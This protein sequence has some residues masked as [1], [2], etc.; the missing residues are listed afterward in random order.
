MADIAANLRAVQERVRDAALRSSRDPDEVELLVV[1]KTWPVPIVEEVIA[2]G[3]TILGENKLQ[4]ASEKIPQLPRADLHWHFI[5]HLQRNKARKALELFGTL[6]SLDSMRL[7]RHVDRIAGELEC[8]PVVY[9]QVNAAGE[10][11][12]SGFSEEEL[13][14]GL[15]ELM[16]LNHLQVRGLMAIPPAVETPAQARASFQA[17]RDLRDRCEAVSGV[18]LPGLSMGMSHDY[19]VAI[20]EGATIVRVGSSIFGPRQPMV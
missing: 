17:L 19:E 13:L 3:A 11:S 1:T 18:S 12:K 4:E 10:A 8:R 5:G 9:L 15:A 20:E 6:H 14:E 2:A 16:A 7:A